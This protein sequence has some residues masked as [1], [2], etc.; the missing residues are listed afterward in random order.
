MV[1]MAVAGT[2]VAAGTAGAIERSLNPETTKAPNGAPFLLPLDPASWSWLLLGCSS[3]LKAAGTS[4]LTTAATRKARS[5]SGFF[6][7]VPELEPLILTRAG[8]VVPTILIQLPASRPV[9]YFAA[10]A[11]S[12]ALITSG[13]SG[14]TFELNRSRILPSR[15]TRNLLKFQVMLPGKGE[16]L[17]ASAT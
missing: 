9:D 6:S 11:A 13:D 12:T 10:S 5:S 15:P 3:G 14:V 16:S 1:I 17:P 7:N 2:A 4:R 8:R